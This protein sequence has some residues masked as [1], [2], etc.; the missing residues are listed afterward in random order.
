MTTRALPGEC[1]C[2]ERLDEDGDCP[3]CILELGYECTRC[4]AQLNEHGHCWHC[5][6]A[7]IWTAP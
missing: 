2:G 3:R 5:D 4:D 6:G 7:W 1:L